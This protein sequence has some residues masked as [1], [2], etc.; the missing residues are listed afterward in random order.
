VAC[1]AQQDA[2]VP[3]EQCLTK[4]RPGYV[5]PLARGPDHLFSPSS[6]HFPVSHD[7]RV[8]ARCCTAYF[9]R[10]SAAKDV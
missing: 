6:R 1:V 7:H 9:D 8:A 10:A 5:T 2:P 3:R 4:T